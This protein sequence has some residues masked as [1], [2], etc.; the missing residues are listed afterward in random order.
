[1][2]KIDNTDAKLLVE[3]D[4]NARQAETTLAK[5]IH[6][7]KESVRYRIKTLEQ[8][9][10]IEGHTIWIDTVQLGYHSA[11][12]Y[13]TLANKPK[14]REEF[15]KYVTQDK[16]LFWLGL[17]DGAWNAGLTY[18]V[19]SNQEFFELKNELF[20]Q[21]KELIT[22]SQIASIVEIGFKNKTFLTPSE[23]VW[24]TMFT[25][26]KTFYTLDAVERKI[27]RALFANGRISLTQLAQQTQ[28]TIDIVR[29]RM[30]KLEEKKII[31]RYG[32]RINY[33]KLGYEFY[34]TFCYFQNL[35]KQ[36]EKKFL[37]YCRKQHPIIHFV[38]TI[39]SWDIE[40][41]SMCK[42]YHE[43]LKIINDLTREFPSIIKVET[44]IMSE[45]YV[46]P[47]KKMIFEE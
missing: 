14:L 5:K 15:V 32:A 12:L 6:R 8:K 4:H 19:T 36:D 30:H 41:E 28:S 40:L 39:S 16:R 11:K 22:A 46:F 45:D 10:V 35:T 24:K 7:S 33:N 18:F 34:K 29:H 23:S 47:A 31:A 37:E 13:L 26:P 9:G 20:S 27:L 2:Y 3:L 1:M 17:A 43:Y 42:S 25:Q 21:F 38:K 44:A